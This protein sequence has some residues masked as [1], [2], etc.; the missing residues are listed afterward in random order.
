MVLIPPR[1]TD[2][3]ANADCL[4]NRSREHAV[5]LPRRHF[6]HLAA[7]IAALPAVSPLAWAEAYPVRPVR[8]IVGFA[9]GGPADIL[10]RLIGQRLAEQLGQPFVIESRLGAGSS[11]AA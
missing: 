7:S 5:K 8:L 10:A 9:S 4:L 6:L 3:Q 2:W 11:V 1:D